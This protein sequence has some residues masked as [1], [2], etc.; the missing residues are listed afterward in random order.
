MTHSRPVPEQRRDPGKAAY[1]PEELDPSR[2][3]GQPSPLRWL[4][5]SSTRQ[6]ARDKG[7][8][9]PQQ[10]CR[11]GGKQKRAGRDLFVSRSSRNNPQ[12]PISLVSSGVLLLQ[13]GKANGHKWRNGED[14]APNRS[15]PSTHCTASSTSR[16]VLSPSLTLR[17]CHFYSLTDRTQKGLLETCQLLLGQEDG[18]GEPPCCHLGPS[19][20]AGTEGGAAS[21]SNA[22]RVLTQHH[23]GVVS[24]IPSLQ[25]LSH[26]R[27]R[28]HPS[29][30]SA[31]LWKLMGC[32]SDN[33]LFL[34]HHF[35]AQAHFAPAEG[36]QSL[37]LP[38]AQDV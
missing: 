8:A 22:S 26:P 33:P 36:N 5:V 17:P 15:D 9:K 37:S 2:A 18:A 14:P 31:K 20:V 1:S 24:A 27:Q 21:P 6:W 12:E 25:L 4:L 10:S 29:T 23:S 11:R 13:Q 38:L 28:G 35:G 7:T 32:S 3:T 19:G 16:T 34:I 30:T